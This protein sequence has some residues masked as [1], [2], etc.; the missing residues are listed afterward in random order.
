MLLLT[1]IMICFGFK[2]EKVWDERQRVLAGMNDT[3]ESARERANTI[4]LFEEKFHRENLKD[5]M[6][7]TGTPAAEDKKLFA[8]LWKTTK[9]A[10]ALNKTLE[11]LLFSIRLNQLADMGG[12]PGL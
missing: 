8:T 10:A 4:K 6:A 1:H 9:I 3:S 7:I 2:P 5:P 12:H 11:S